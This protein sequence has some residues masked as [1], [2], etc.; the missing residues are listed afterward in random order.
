MLVF[1]ITSSGEK[2]LNKLRRMT[3]EVK[4]I[5]YNTKI[6]N[7]NIF[8]SVVSWNYERS[9]QKYLRVFKTI[10]DN[11]IVIKKS[12]SD[13]NKIFNSLIVEDKGVQIF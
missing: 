1:I 12:I 9:L 8:N 10:S 5:S 3:N 6:N 2:V 7:G 11:F 13:R 4:L